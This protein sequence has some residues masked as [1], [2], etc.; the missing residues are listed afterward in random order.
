MKVWLSYGFLISA[1]LLCSNAYAQERMGK[2]EKSFAKIGMKEGT[3]NVTVAN[4]FGKKW[5]MRVNYP[6]HTKEANSLIIALHWAGGGDTFREFNDCL[7][8]PGLEF[9]N[10]IIV[11]PEGENQ[12]WSS[13]NNE[14]K[15]LSVVT[16]AKKYWNV[17]SNKIAVVGYSNGGNG[18]WYFAEK[19]PGMFSA[20]IPMASAYALTKKIDIP[21]YVIHG[22]QD[23]L[24]DIARTEKWVNQTKEKGSEVIFKAADGLSHYE[25]CAYIELLKEAGEW[26]EQKWK[27]Q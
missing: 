11:S 2:A 4:D 18:S 25:A 5:K 13:A 9:L 19:Y 24:F 17:D 16:N 22:Q 8:V 20:A 15:V 14:D 21:V 6:E 12:L 23:E 1:I 3:R 7:V 26:L 27:E 10:P